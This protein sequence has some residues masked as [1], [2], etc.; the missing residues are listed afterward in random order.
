[1]LE[2]FSPKSFKISLHDHALTLRN[3][4]EI[5]LVPPSMAHGNGGQ[6]ARLV[7]PRLAIVGTL[8]DSCAELSALDGGWVAAVHAPRQHN[9]D[10]IH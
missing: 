3:D 7:G 9:V 4:I 8:P 5:G 10:T 1:M 6:V 2:R